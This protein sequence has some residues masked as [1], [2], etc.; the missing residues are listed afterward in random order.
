MTAF[1]GEVK[2]AVIMSF[3]AG[4]GPFNIRHALKNA[5]DEKLMVNITQCL[6]GEVEKDY[7][8]VNNTLYANLILRRKWTMD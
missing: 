2:G 6:K 3:G 4:N 7:A 1:L 8:T 5:S